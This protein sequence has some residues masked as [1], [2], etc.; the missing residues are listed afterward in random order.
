[1]TKAVTTGTAVTTY[2]FFNYI[3]KTELSCIRTADIDI[4]VYRFQKN[5]CGASLLTLLLIDRYGRF[6]PPWIAVPLFMASYGPDCDTKN[7][8]FQTSP[9]DSDHRRSTRS[10][11]F[12][13]VTFQRA[14]L[15]NMETVR[16]VY[17]REL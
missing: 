5:F 8:D 11:I 7:V 4:W 12:C 15:E 14:I 3:Y 1:M 9:N 2:G 16:N 6:D 17:L 10:T 13:Y